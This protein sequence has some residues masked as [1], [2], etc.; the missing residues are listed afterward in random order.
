MFRVGVTTHDQALSLA[1]ALECE[2]GPLEIELD[3]RKWEEKASRDP[4]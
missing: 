4:T 3:E 1:H 2:K